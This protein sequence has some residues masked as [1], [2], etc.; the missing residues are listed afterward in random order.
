MRKRSGLRAVHLH[1]RGDS[2]GYHEHAALRIG[3]SPRAWKQRPRQKGR[4]LGDRFISTCVETALTSTRPSSIAAVHLHVRGDSEDEQQATS[5]DIGSSP[6]AWRQPTMFDLAIST[7]GSS[8]RVRHFDHRR[9]ISTCVE[10]AKAAGEIVVRVPVHLHVRG[11]SAAF[12][13]SICF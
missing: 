2:L 9:F 12:R 6:R 7:N 8:P 5:A 4:H 1:V 11:D 13:L 10:T 3:S